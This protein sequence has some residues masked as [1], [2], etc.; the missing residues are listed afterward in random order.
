MTAKPVSG[1]P[2]Q[3]FTAETVETLAEKVK[4]LKKVKEMTIRGTEG[5]DLERARINGWFIAC[6]FDGPLEKLEVIKVK[7]Q[8]RPP[9]GD[10]DGSMSIE[11]WT[12]LK[13]MIDGLR[14]FTIA[15]EKLQEDT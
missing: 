2:T 10:A 9:L 6:E 14:S 11:Q 1:K 15:Y 4:E 12:A 5:S 7:A 8:N 3:F 13:D